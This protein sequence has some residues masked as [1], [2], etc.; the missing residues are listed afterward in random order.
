MSWAVRGPVLGVDF[1][2]MKVE[3]VTNRGQS[4]PSAPLD[5]WL[6]VYQDWSKFSGRKPLL[7][8]LEKVRGELTELKARLKERGSRQYA[9]QLDCSAIPS[10]KVLDRINRYETSNVRHRY[11]VEAR[12]EQVQA[13]RREDAKLNS[14]EN[15][16][17]DQLQRTD[18]CETK[19]NGHA[20]GE[21]PPNNSGVNEA[22]QE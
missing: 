12:L 8:A 1:L 10:K 16:D 14:R 18:F 2:L 11:R 15:I 9:N 6:A 17:V 4:M 13:R 21:L 22:E 20:N 19:P 5:R 3:E 7:A